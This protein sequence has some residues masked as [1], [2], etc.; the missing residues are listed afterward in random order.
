MVV[1]FKFLPAEYES[2]SR[3]ISLATLG[4]VSLLN[5]VHPYRCVAVSP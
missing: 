5:F 2:T 1:P 4:I 3:L